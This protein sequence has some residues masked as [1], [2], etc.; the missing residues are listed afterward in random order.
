MFT[1]V[2]K[3]T[4]AHSARPPT[5]QGLWEALRWGQ[6]S[7][8]LEYQTCTSAYPFDTLVTGMGK[9]TIHGL[10]LQGSHFLGSS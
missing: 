5:V 4:P 10:R 1:P 2:G 6:G 7:I 3:L 9:V 8:S